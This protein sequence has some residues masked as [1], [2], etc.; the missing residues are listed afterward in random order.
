MR[1]LM[2]TII[3]L[4]S[5][6]STGAFEMLHQIGGDQ[7]D[8]LRSPTSASSAAHLVLSFSLCV[9]SSP[10]VISSNSSSSFGSSLC[11]QTEL[12]DAALVVDRH[13]GLV[14]HGALDVVDGDV[15]AEHRP[16]V[17]VGLFD[18]RAGEADERRVRQRIAQM[19]RAR[20]SIR[21]YWL[22]CASSAITTILRRFESSGIFSP[23]SGSELLDR[24]EH[25][26]AAGHVQQFAQMLADSRPAP[27]S[28]RGCSW[29][30][31][32]WPNS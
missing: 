1:R 21:S 2:Q 16:R 6:A 19:C 11:V 12:G 29:Q 10:S 25:H 23:F 22:R 31:W 18:R 30:R 3:A 15:V 4:P 14:G 13:R 5:I 24:G 9:S 32:N 8:A 26:A 7:R 20:P 17:G 27:A 28:G